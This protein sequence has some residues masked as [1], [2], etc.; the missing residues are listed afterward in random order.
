MLRSQEVLEAAWTKSW[1]QAWCSPKIWFDG[2]R[3]ENLVRN[4]SSGPI[5]PSV[6]FRRRLIRF[7]EVRTCCDQR[8][9]FRLGGGMR[10]DEVKASVP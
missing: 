6:S 4:R 3:I 10:V 9:D 7:G 2:T 1:F 8:G 5:G